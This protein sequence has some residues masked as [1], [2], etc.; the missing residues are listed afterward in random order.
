MIAR[1]A[2]HP[3]VAAWG[4]LSGL[5]RREALAAAQGPSCRAYARGAVSTEEAFK[6]DKTFQLFLQAIKPMKEE[7]VPA[8]SEEELATAKHMTDKWA[9]LRRAEDI[10]WR[11][12]INE[13]IRLRDAA[14]AA[15]PEPLRAAALEPDLAPFPLARWI[16]T[17]SPPARLDDADPDEAADAAQE[18]RTEQDVL[19]GKVGAGRR[20]RG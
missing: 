19:R 8:M 15:L 5:A 13:K 12:D 11:S 7:D 17:E 20:Q 2:F 18:Q 14:I 16:A 9:Q 3:C 1:R 6:D 10:A 4:T